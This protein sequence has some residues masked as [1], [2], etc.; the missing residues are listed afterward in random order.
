MKKKTSK[1]RSEAVPPS[2]QEVPIERQDELIIRIVKR[3]PFEVARALDMTIQGIPGWNQF[4]EFVRFK[5]SWENYSKLVNGDID[6]LQKK[7]I[8]DMAGP[9]LLQRLL[10]TLDNEKSALISDMVVPYFIGEHHDEEALKALS[11]DRL[12]FKIWGENLFE[13]YKNDAKKEV[14][15]IS[16][17]VSEWEHEKVKRL[18]DEY[19][20][21]QPGASK[22]NCYGAIGENLGKST[23]DVKRLYKYVPKKG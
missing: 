12:A 23:E 9:T 6:T 7:V 5:D 20:L 17:E 1:S 13:E 11:L 10:S 15:K 3:L 22:A 18:V 16:S 8:H 14:D 2:L 4:R 21:K 19:Q